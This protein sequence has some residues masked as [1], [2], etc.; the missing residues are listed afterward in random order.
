MKTVLV[1]LSFFHIFSTFA[2]E[3]NVVKVSDGSTAYCQKK[4]DVYRHKFQVYSLSSVSLEQDNEQV[5]LNFNISF[6]ECIE[7]D[8]KFLFNIVY[9]AVPFSYQTI[10]DVDTNGQ[11]VISIVEAQ[12]EF[13]RALIY[14]DGE[15]KLLADYK[16][17]NK[18]LSFSIRLDN[19]LD[20]E[21]IASLDRGESVKT[22]FDFA[23]QRKLKLRSDAGS[24]E[25]S[26]LV[27]YGAFRFHF[28]L[29][30]SDEKFN[31]KVL[32]Q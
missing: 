15:Y 20:R 17:S 16:F 27:N 10:S 23:V 19:L 21:A 11:P 4:T 30:K 31:I 14:V 7:R 22:S 28:E 5:Q 13:L 2:T 25:S 32:K 3:V 6:K 8:G 12:T 9:P 18:S 29:S 26:H 1:L 24:S